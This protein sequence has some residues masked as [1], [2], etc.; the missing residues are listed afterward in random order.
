MVLVCQLL[1]CTDELLG[2]EPAPEFVQCFVKFMES[3]ILWR[4]QENVWGVYACYKLLDAE[5]TPARVEVLVLL[6]GLQ[7][8]ADYE[9]RLHVH[10][11]LA[12]VVRFRDILRPLELVQFSHERL[13][14]QSV[15][16]CNDFMEYKDLDV[17]RKRQGLQKRP[18]HWI[19]ML[20]DLHKFMGREFDPHLLAFL[21]AKGVFCLEGW[22]HKLGQIFHHCV[23][24]ALPA[25]H[26][27][28]V[29]HAWSAS[30][31]EPAVVVLFFAEQLILVH[32]KHLNNI[33][34]TTSCQ[35][36]DAAEIL[37]N[38]VLGESAL[39]KT[40]VSSPLAFPFAIGLGYRLR[41]YGGEQVW[42]ARAKTL[43]PTGADLESVHSTGMWDLVVE[44]DPVPCSEK[45]M[46]DLS[47]V[48]NFSLQYSYLCHACCILQGLSRP[49]R[50]KPSL[51]ALAH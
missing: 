27:A 49:H 18:L 34:V 2:H 20:D 45:L 32:N 1:H 8:L 47:H 10:T 39:E 6:Y 30:S 19:S 5:R 14:D 7:S 16:F 15:Q 17:Y 40:K 26:R 13:L 33:L 50:S 31:K 41:L 24:Q 46:L 36:G 48:N 11:P 51:L 4:A 21:E 43:A 35:E 42:L 37:C 38:F 3:T 29:L 12:G 28:E 22:A 25:Q 44:I 9:A 23:L